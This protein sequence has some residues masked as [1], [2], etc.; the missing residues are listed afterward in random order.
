MS[1]FSNYDSF[2]REN[3]LRLRNTKL[4]RPAVPSYSF[5]TMIGRN[6]CLGCPINWSKY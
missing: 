5:Q 1:V 3:D 6:R 2:T 4:D